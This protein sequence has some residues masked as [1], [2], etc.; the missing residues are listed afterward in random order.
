MGHLSRGKES[1]DTG[2][3]D[4]SCVEVDSIGLSYS[5]AT[6]DESRGDSIHN[7]EMACN[8]ASL[9]AQIVTGV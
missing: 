2:G 7:G 4:H 6:R 1:E 9:S 3:V 5:S 8:Q